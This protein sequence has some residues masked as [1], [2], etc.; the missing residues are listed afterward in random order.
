MKEVKEIN[1][2]PVRTVKRL[3][4]YLHYLRYLKEENVRNISSTFIGNEL[5]LEATQVKKDIQYT[6]ITGRPRTGYEVARLIDEIELVLNWQVKKKAI[7]AG[8]GHLGSAM[9]GYEAFNRYGID[10]LRAFDVDEKKIGKKIHGIE[11]MHIDEMSDFIR[12]N[13]VKIGVLTVPA[14]N[15]Q[16][17]AM[18]M[19]EGGAKAIWNFVPYQLKVPEGIIVEHAQFSQSLAVL[20]QKLSKIESREL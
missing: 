20:T 2:I 15:A 13:E 11:V 7:L 16:D 3:S 19:I 14:K 9:L 1:D 10:F 5:G 17:T 18:L 12:E 8:A 6:G 4:R